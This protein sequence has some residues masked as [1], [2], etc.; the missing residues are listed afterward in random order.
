MYQIIL[1]IVCK[2]VFRIIRIQPKILVRT[3]ILWGSE[4]SSGSGLL[5][6]TLLGYLELWRNV[7]Y[8]Y[9]TAV[10]KGE[11][12]CLSLG[13]STSNIRQFCVK[14][15]PPGQESWSRWHIEVGSV[16]YC[17]WQPR[18]GC[19]TGNLRLPFQRARSPYGARQDILK[20]STFTL[21]L[22]YSSLIPRVCVSRALFSYRYQLVYSA[23]WIMR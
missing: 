5:K 13:L 11:P 15:L 3:R 21:G 7:I 22:K 17:S 19:A 8:I 4:C 16:W 9:V 14:T 6:K 18:A 12:T 2:A 20:L 23:L 1:S 10:V